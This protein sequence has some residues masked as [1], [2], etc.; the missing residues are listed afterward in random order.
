MPWHIECVCFARRRPLS[1]WRPIDARRIT[2]DA[3]LLDCVYTVYIICC[4]GAAATAAILFQ[5]KLILKNFLGT[6]AAVAAAAAATVSWCVKRLRC[7]CANT[8]G[9]LLI[10]TLFAGARKRPPIREGRR[11]VRELPCNYY[12]VACLLCVATTKRIKCWKHHGERH[13]VVPDE[14]ARLSLVIFNLKYFFT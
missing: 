3:R 8:I 2:N 13:T 5:V 10:N 7:R 6:L 12:N 11:I 9:P 14:I 1:V 4:V